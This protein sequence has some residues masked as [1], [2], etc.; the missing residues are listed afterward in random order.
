MRLVLA[1][2]QLVDNRGH[3]I[4]LHRID[5]SMPTAANIAIGKAATAVGFKPSG[6]ILEHAVTTYIIA[7]LTL[8]SIPPSL[9]A[10]Q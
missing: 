8:K 4:S 3:L 6:A 7:M 2:Q 9:F 1:E 10:F 5:G